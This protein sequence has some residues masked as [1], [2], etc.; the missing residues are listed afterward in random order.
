ML[1]A[2]GES[3]T[4]LGS[5]NTRSLIANVEVSIFLS[6]LG[7]ALQALTLL[8]PLQ[9]LMQ[10]PLVLERHILLVCN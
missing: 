5:S 6:D 2:L 10:E 3:F 1:S 7:N 4:C 9:I 8:Q